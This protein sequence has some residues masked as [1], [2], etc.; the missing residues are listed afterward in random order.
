MMEIVRS[1][2]SM[3]RNV[4]TSKSK[5]PPG[6]TTLTCGGNDTATKTAG[7]SAGDFELSL[8]K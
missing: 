4:D 6:L 3:I 5:R 1:K 2:G 8:I 7:T